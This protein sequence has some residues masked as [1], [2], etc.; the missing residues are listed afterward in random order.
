M[1]NHD[2]Q[3]L[4]RFALELAKASAAEILPHFRR[5]GAVDNKAAAHFDPV[6]EGDRAGERAI[7]ALIEKT[8]PDHGILGEEYGEKPSRSGLTWILDPIDGTRAFVCGMPTW[9]TLIGLACEGEPVLGVMNQPYVGDLFYGNPEGAWLDHRG[10]TLPIR[11]RSGVRLAEA[12]AGTTA[13]EL[14]KG[15]EAEHF[16]RLRQT[17]KM[18]RFGGDAYFFAVLAG[19]HLDIAMDPALQP[20]DIAALIPIIKGAGGAVGSWSGTNPATGGNVITAGSEALLQAAIETM[21]G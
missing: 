3:E 20:Y 1:L 9:G 10:V 14:Y 8:Y 5:N 4:T 12:C 11:A 16:G 7:R 15:A 21:V 17:V 18:M 19:G 2:W 13:P 6:T